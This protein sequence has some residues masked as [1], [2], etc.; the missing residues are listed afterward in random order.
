MEEV[1]DSWPQVSVNN[2]MESRTIAPMNFLPLSTKNGTPTLTM[3][4]MIHMI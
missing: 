3:K 4:R 2:N 1:V